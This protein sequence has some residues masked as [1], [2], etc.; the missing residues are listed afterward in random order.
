MAQVAA[1]NFVSI[2]SIMD[3]LELYKNNPTAIQRVILDALDEITNGTVNVVDP[4]TPFIFL[5]EASACNT[6]F[7]VNEAIAVLG[8]QYPSLSQTEDDLYHHM[9]D[10]DYLNR[11]SAPSSGKFKVV[12]LVSDIQ[13]KMVWSA[14]DNAFKATFP[15]D[16]QFVVD[17]YTFTMLY[18]ID[19]RCFNNGVV[20]LSYDT[21]ITSPIDDVTNNIIPYTIRKDANQNQWLLFELSVNQFQITSTDFA[22]QSGTVFSQDLPYTDQFYYTRA[23][24]RNTNTNNQWQ[25]MITTHSDMVYDATKPTVVLEVFTGY[26]TAMIPQVYL[27]TGLVTGDVRIDVYSSKGD[28]IV[29]LSNYKPESFSMVLQA[30]DETRDLNVFTSAMSNLTYYG[31]SDDTITGGT[32]GVDYATLRDR[33]ITNSNGPQIVPISPTAIHAKIE[34]NGFTLVKNVDVT[35]NRIFLATQKL[36]KPS[37]PKL[38]TSANIGISPFITNFDYLKT[39]STVMINVDRATIL[40]SNL[41]KSDN[42]V[43]SIL[44]SSQVA[45][46][47]AM[48]KLQ[49][50]QEVNNNNYLY[51]PYYYVLDD[52]NN[53]FAVRAYDLDYP[54]ASNLSFQSQNQS[55]QLPVNTGSYTFIKTPQGYRLTLLTTSGEFYK[56]LPD[57]TVFTQIGYYP[58]GE[59]SMAYI[60]GI[61]SGK[62]ENNERQWTFDIITN[63]D[64][65]SDDSITI[66]NA[67]MFSD[68][69]LNTWATLLQTVHVFYMT[70]SIT[71]GFSPDET[72]ALLGKFIL[73]AGVVADTHETLNLQM[74]Q[75]L[76]TLWTRSRSI[77]SGL[78]YK[79]YTLDVPMLY[80][81][82]VYD[83]NPV[84]GSTIFFATDGSIYRNK[85]NSFGD[86]VLDNSGN[87]VYKHRSG[88]VV[89]DATTGQPVVESSLTVDKEADIL[90]VDG[91]Q[92][93]VDDPAFLAYNAEIVSVVDS[94]IVNDLAAIQQVL[95]E[96]T[97]V[98]FYPKTTL[99]QVSVFTK[100]QGQD[101]LPA[102]QSLTVDLYVKDDVYNDANVRSQLTLKTVTLLDDYI[103]GAVVNITE[104]TNALAALYG[105]SVQSLNVSG[106]G[107]VKDYK[108]LTLA[109]EQY[110]LCLKKILAIQLDGA[111]IIEEDVTV[112]FYRI[113]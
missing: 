31:Y 73:P 23:F 55:L 97:K 33:V 83:V 48:T 76:K 86:P 108:I 44:T 49:L 64:L 113:P 87:Q 3:N 71:Q 58:V 12:M 14:T 4:T 56:G 85:L 72:D 74:G 63:Y 92:Y 40:S 45:A 36:P 112:N 35:T 10:Q 95:L 90:F 32:N 93:F 42:G 27:T 60:N 22:I 5:L 13:N 100:D 70:N 79:L 94:W 68:E 20:Q 18:P 109:N 57:N 81:Q 75:S 101:T 91:R 105:I 28:L 84:T 62:D 21:T 98:Y 110:R 24:Y 106:L 2:Q 67:K 59:N 103:S 61:M 65:N 52:S 7:A 1:T 51:S 29:N 82:D 38:T 78:N 111:L 47:K 89:L 96:Q 16:T 107:G 17:N 15:R 39:L 19:V 30:I 6:A 9:S 69:S 50:T 54:V 41:Y 102:E 99:G 66:T 77:A 46:L 43:V 80:D 37:N 25:E 53:E 26:V 34:N 11:F 88:D 8:K 104:I